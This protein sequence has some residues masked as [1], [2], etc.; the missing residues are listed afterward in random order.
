MGGAAFTFG[1][2]LDQALTLYAVWTANA[3]TRYTVIHWLENAD[4]NEYSYRESETRTGATGAQTSAAA[5]S[6]TGF[7][8]RTIAQQTIAGD[9]STIVSGYYK[10]NG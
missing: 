2:P 4:D 3:N 1:P 9:G 8:A 10:R 7:T 6:Y 5:K